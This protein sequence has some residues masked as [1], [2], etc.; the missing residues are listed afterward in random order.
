MFVLRQG[1]CC[2]QTAPASRLLEYAGSIAR[3]SAESCGLCRESSSRSSRHRVSTATHHSS[4]GGMRSVLE[5]SLSQLLASMPGSTLNGTQSHFP[6]AFDSTTQYTPQQACNGSIQN[7]H[8]SG[9]EANTPTHTT[10][11]SN[12]AFSSIGNTSAVSKATEE[13]VMNTSSTIDDLTSTAPVSRRGKPQHPSQNAVV[14][15]DGDDTEH[16]ETMEQATINA[17]NPAFSFSS[18]NKP[19]SNAA[20]SYSQGPGSTS[21]IPVADSCSV[22][23]PPIPRYHQPQPLPRAGAAFS[24][25][26]P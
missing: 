14:D 23:V 11:T 8:N 1:T 6:S 15:V 17:S 4:S 22:R 21:S 5:P 19:H 9:H 2:Q 24:Y 25:F 7:T 20:F 12:G 26:L 10:K 16:H 3:L 13:S 18:S